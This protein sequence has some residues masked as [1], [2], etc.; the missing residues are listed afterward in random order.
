MKKYIVKLLFLCFLLIIS[1]VNAQELFTKY[2]NVAHDHENPIMI[3]T[4]YG[5]FSLWISAMYAGEQ[6]QAGGLVVK[7][8]MYKRF[9]EG[10]N[11]A[12]MEYLTFKQNI[13]TGK[14]ENRLKS[15]DVEVNTDA[16]FKENELQYHQNALLNFSITKDES[17][18]NCYLV[19]ETGELKSVV[20]TNIRS[21]GFKIIFS[22]EAEINHFLNIISPDSLNKYMENQ[23]GNLVKIERRIEKRNIE[24][25]KAQPWLAYVETGFKGAFFSSFYLNPIYNSY[26]L[27]NGSGAGFFGRLYAGKFFIQPELMY[28]FEGGN[29]YME[30]LDAYLS[31]IKMT[32]KVSSQFI[33]IPLQ[34][35]YNIFNASKLHV[36]LLAGPQL[37]FNTYSNV[38][39]VYFHTYSNTT[40]SE[41]NDDIK[42]FQVGY[43]AGVD[44]D[45]YRLSLGTRYNFYRNMFRTRYNANFI[46]DNNASTISFQLAWKLYKPA[47]K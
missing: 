42:K 39:Y 21:S 11:V 2:N 9:Y 1:N 40:L 12:K 13:E 18:K 31:T 38:D 20:Y 33:S 32:K 26:S 25:I 29:T 14:S 45:Y 28:N 35:G 34:L 36:H 3:S 43:T 7:E 24:S 5:Q 37:R 10:L 47:T 30:F 27:Y 16:Y 19:I 44:I 22:N 17:N 23:D 46:D 15:L 6:M 8:D 41:F 4:K